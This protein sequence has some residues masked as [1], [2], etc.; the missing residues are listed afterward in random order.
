M[1]CPLGK[2]IGERGLKELPRSLRFISAAACLT[3]AI[4]SDLA[5]F[6]TFVYTQIC[7]AE[8]SGDTNTASMDERKCELNAE[9]S[10]GMEVR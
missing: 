4:E 5:F 2:G 9:W 1:V 10:V 7:H 6:L 8:T 3:F